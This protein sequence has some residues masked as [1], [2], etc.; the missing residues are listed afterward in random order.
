M[1]IKILAIMAAL[2]AGAGFSR[3][4]IIGNTIADDGDG[5][6]TCYTY[7]F[8]KTGDHAFQ[9]S[10]DGSQNS[11]DIG[12][13]LGDII[14]DTETD[15]TLTLFN[16]IDNDTGVSWNDYH[17]TV[18]MSK[19]F[20]LS[21]VGVVNVGWTFITTQP[22]QVGSDWIGYIDYYAGNLVPN[23]GTL[24]FSYAMA[25]T[26]GASFE[27]DLMPSTVP[28]PTTT[29]CFLLGLGALICCQRIHQKPTFQIN[30]R[31]IQNV[32]T[33]ISPR[34]NLACSQ[35]SSRA[36]AKKPIRKTKLESETYSSRPPQKNQLKKG[37][38]QRQKQK[39]NMKI[40]KLQVAIMAAALAAASSASA[41]ITLTLDSVGQLGQNNYVT[42]TLFSSAL[43][44][45]ESGV[46]AGIYNLTVN[47]VATP[48]FCIDIATEQTEGTPYFD[49]NYTALASAPV[50]SV[51][52][53]GSAAATDIEKLW[54]Q[55][56]SPSMGIQDAAALQVAI[57]EDMANN[58]G[59]NN[60]GPYTLTVSGNDPVTSEASTMLDSLPGLTVEADLIALTDNGQGYV[61]AVPEPT[62]AGCFL[63][64]LGALVCFQRFTQKRRS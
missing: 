32:T 27:E 21:A 46:E 64:G 22:T 6:M 47:S 57:W 36:P 4:D 55:Y 20:S 29:G 24:D 14:T 51:G 34:R 41:Q 30:Q 25:F 23:G 53:M 43:G 42:V 60:G 48:S 15:P 7:G 58:S 1:K 45:N 10:I 31:N 13:I 62:A 26:G 35:N 54:A 40:R 56:Y 8:L 11:W 59:G 16:E 52:P 38:Q 18:T 12:N 37:Q 50:D 2:L 44:I 28:E 39:G 33:S 5:V 49:Y 9:L 17:V 63:L 19:S 61:V 3:A